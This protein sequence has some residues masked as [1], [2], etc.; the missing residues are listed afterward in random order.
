MRRVAQ[1][2]AAVLAASLACCDLAPVYQPPKYVLPASYQGAGPWQIA[3][4]QDKIARGSWWERYGNPVL[5]QL[6]A[7]LPNNPD[8]LAEREAFTQARELAAEAESGLYPQIGLNG[9]ASNNRQSPQ[10]LFR[11]YT[12]T[13]PLV[14]PSVQVDAEA[15]WEIDIWD[16]I[17]NQ[18]KYQKNLAQAEAAYVA[19]V[20]L[21]L[22]AELANA[23]I[24]L[25]GL[26]Q[27]G[28]LYQQSVAT[29]QTGLNIT[30]ARLAGKI[31]NS[32]DVA[33]AQ[34]QLSSTQALFEDNAA[35]R[36]L[37]QH[38]IADLIGESASTFTLPQQQD[39]PLTVPKIPAGL[40]SDL[41][42]RRPDIAAAERDMAAANAEIGVSRAAFYPNIS[43]SGL[44]GTQDRGFNL[45]SLPNAVWSI[46]SQIALPLFE[47]GL[48]RAEL[49]F[50]KS[51]YAQT[52][53]RYRSVVLSAFQQVEDQLSLNDLLA[54]EAIQD[55]QAFQAA[56]QAQT[57]SLQLY[58]A[59][60][61]NYLDVVVSQVTALQAQTSQVG[62]DARVQQ[63]SINLVRALGGG[64][65][66]AELP[67]EKQIR[68]FNPLIPGDGLN[69]NRD[70]HPPG[71]G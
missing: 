26:D 61:G 30:Q 3:H 27:Q 51:A 70:S 2:A 60:A 22:Q 9:F 11:S 4:P 23:Y 52:R 29:Y 66:A 54:K 37:A 59:G 34:T 48:R 58:T 5:D 16:R 47:G 68:P 15:N 42:Q 24:T 25:R 67:T 13:S 46:G 45:I 63:A 1:A 18:A 55:Q 28:K 69:A 20:E 56:G 12:S 62:I 65:S 44:A 39:T 35:Q 6:E 19:F 8:L 7:R 14:E 64:W 53:D 40:P 57:L 31:G 43:L 17:G 38:A 36:A 41:L 33:R 32:L 10:R 49:G 50:A 71:D 21:S